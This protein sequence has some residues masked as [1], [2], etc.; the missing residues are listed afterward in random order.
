[1]TLPAGPGMQY[2]RAMRELYPELEPFK[3]ELIKASPLHEIYVEQCGNPDGQPI[4]FLHGGPGGGC[5][6]MHRRFFD[7]AHYRIILLDQRGAGRSKPSAEVEENTTWDLVHDV[8][9]VRK[10]LGFRTWIVFGGSWGS[11]LALA[12]ATKH[13]TRVRGLILRGI[14]LCRKEEIDWFY[15][16]GASFVFP[17]LWEKYLEPVPP[18]ERGSL[19]QAY[20]RLLIES[21]NENDRLRAAKAWCQWE[22]GTSYLHFRQDSVDAFEDAKHALE[23]ARI[24]N[25]Y[26]FHKAFFETDDYL[27]AHADNLRG[28][29]GVIVHGRYDVV[30]PV[31]NAFD[32]HKAWP[33]AQLHVVPDA[34]HSAFE[35]GIQDK[36]LEA[37]DAFKALPVEQ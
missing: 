30:C 2:K 31:K 3:S 35:P 32:L 25:H 14:F 1:M 4:I 36:L 9:L 21:P 12:Y 15:Q 34:G 11:T 33:E 22:G 17:E 5:S 20:H 13:P 29:P 27:L 23:F 6:P 24:E 7:P 28:I 26:F 37:T 16:Q 10:H 8:E 19:V 18:E